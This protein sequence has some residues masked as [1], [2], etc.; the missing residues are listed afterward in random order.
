VEV[1][2]SDTSRGLGDAKLLVDVTALEQAVVVGFGTLVPGNEAL[3][4]TLLDYM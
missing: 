2:T 3:L 1:T 4:A